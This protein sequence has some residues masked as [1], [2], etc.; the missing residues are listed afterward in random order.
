M[1]KIRRNYLFSPMVINENYGYLEASSSLLN[2]HK[3]IINNRISTSGAS[4]Q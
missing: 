3:K 2:E 4:K 1:S